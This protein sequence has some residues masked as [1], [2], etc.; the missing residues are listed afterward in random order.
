MDFHV[1]FWENATDIV[2][3]RYYNSEFLQKIAAVDVH[4]KSEPYS[5]GLDVNKMIQIFFNY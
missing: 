5:K 2:S 1:H 4:Q 3:T